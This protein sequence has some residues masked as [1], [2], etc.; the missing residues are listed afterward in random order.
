MDI[1]QQLLNICNETGNSNIQLM[2]SS[3]ENGKGITLLAKADDKPIL[4]VKMDTAYEKA[5]EVIAET[6]FAETQKQDLEVVANYQKWITEE[7]NVPADKKSAISKSLDALQNKMKKTADKLLNKVLTA[8]KLPTVKEKNKIVVKE[9][10]KESLLA[11]LQRNKEL[12]K[13]DGDSDKKIKQ[14]NMER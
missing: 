4:S 12:V 10:A 7:S 11:K 9:K 1:A 14:K 6:V 3:W 8:L 13:K 2:T 5:C